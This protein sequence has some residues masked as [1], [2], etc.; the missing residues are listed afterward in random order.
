MA[1]LG[2]EKEERTVLQIEP[3]LASHN[4]YK[5][6]KLLLKT[7]QRIFKNIIFKDIRERRGKQRTVLQIEPSLASH[8][9]YK[10]LNYR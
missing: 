8:N 4:K 10:K 1:F 2:A 6:T 3:S 7:T 9:K 5:K